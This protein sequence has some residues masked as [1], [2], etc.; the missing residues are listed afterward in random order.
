MSPYFVFYYLNSRSGINL[1]PRTHSQV[2]LS[3]SPLCQ[4]MLSRNSMQP[5]FNTKEDK[6]CVRSLISLIF[7]SA[8]MSFM[9]RPSKATLLRWATLPSVKSTP[10]P[11]AMNFR[12]DCFIPT[13]SLSR[14]LCYH[15]LIVVWSALVSIMNPCIKGGCSGQSMCVIFYL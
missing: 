12:F 7:T 10:L 11:Q 15:P 5:V 2:S 1:H 8:L 14:Y 6:W 4:V 3:A 13:A 9:T